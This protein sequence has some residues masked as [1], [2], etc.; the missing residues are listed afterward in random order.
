MS[1]SGARVPAKDAAVVL[2][3]ISK[4]QQHALAEAARGTATA[5][6]DVRNTLLVQA[7]PGS[8]RK[9][10]GRLNAVVGNAAVVLPVLLDSEGQRFYPTGTTRVLFKARP[11]R[12][13]IAEFARQH[14][15]GRA[16][17]NDWSPRQIAFAVRADD[18]RFLVDIV[19]AIDA[20][21]AVEQAWADTRAT[22]RRAAR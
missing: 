22:Y 8:A 19:K 20:D 14:G 18:T 7:R 15:L 21:P 16:R 3:K 12:D 13:V 10:V 1:S 2:G 17:R 9:L 11:S 6:P 4:A 5:M